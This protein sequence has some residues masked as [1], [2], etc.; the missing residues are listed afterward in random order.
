MDETVKMAER[1]WAKIGLFGFAAAAAIT[2]SLEK[3]TI[4]E[5][6]YNKIVIEGG[7]HGWAILLLVLFALY[8]QW[9]AT[10]ASNRTASLNEAERKLLETNKKLN[11]MI[12]QWQNIATCNIRLTN[13][14]NT[15]NAFKVLYWVAKQQKVLQDIASEHEKEIMKG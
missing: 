1:N 11:E 7:L 13:S 12:Y 6:L 9:L 3:V 14:T 2:L 15:Q 5:T 10:G 8:N 4:A